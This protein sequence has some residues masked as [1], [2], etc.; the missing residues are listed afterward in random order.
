M[1]LLRDSVETIEGGNLQ[2][3]KIKIVAQIPKSALQ[4]VQVAVD[5]DLQ[6]FPNLMVELRHFLAL[7]W[8]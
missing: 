4:E 8:Y 2:S 5:F 7:S 1:R 3:E 6:Y